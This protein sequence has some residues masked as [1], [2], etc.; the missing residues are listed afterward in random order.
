MKIE[1]QIQIASATSSFELYPDAPVVILSA[2]TA[3][4]CDLVG[5]IVAPACV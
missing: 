4:C 3:V 5:V 2:G 1:S